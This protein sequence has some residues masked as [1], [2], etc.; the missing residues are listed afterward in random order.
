MYEP[1]DHKENPLS[2]SKRNTP[3]NYKGN[4]QSVF[5]R[6]IPLKIKKK[7]VLSVIGENVSK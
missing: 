3:S 7:E 1:P 5:I 2:V 6:D 4:I